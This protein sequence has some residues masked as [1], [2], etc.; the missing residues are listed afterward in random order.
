MSIEHFIGTRISQREH[1]RIIR[2]CKHKQISKSEL[3]RQLI[4]DKLDDNIK[5]KKQSEYNYKLM[6]EIAIIRFIGTAIL[7]KIYGEDYKEILIKVKKSAEY[8]IK[9]IMEDKL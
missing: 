8:Y 6:F 9:K 5:H 2:H 3:L 4:N 7:N 1:K